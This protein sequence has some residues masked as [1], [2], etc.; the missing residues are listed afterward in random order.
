MNSWLD[1]EKMTGSDVEML[2]DM[3]YLHRLQI[4]HKNFAKLSLARRQASQCPVCHNHNSCNFQKHH[5][6]KG[7]FYQHICSTCF[8]ED[9]EISVHSALD[10]K[11]KK[12]KKRVT[13]GIVDKAK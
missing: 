2:R 9:G 11:S 6:T 3:W 7:V 10:C 13:L 12:F 8:P 5:E 4:T 1:M